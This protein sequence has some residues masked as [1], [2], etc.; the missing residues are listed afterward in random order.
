MEAWKGSRMSATLVTPPVPSSMLLVLPGVLE[1]RGR[2]RALSL[3]VIVL[4]GEISMVP[5][6]GSLYEGQ[7]YEG[8]L[9]AWLESCRG[10]QQ[11]AYIGRRGIGRATV[12]ET[13]GGRRRVGLPHAR[14]GG[15][16]GPA[17]VGDGW[18]RP[19][20]VQASGI[21]CTG[22]WRRWVRETSVAVVG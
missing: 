11:R 12:Q 1:H 15:Y 5:W 10:G 16:T 13:R 4:P 20:D 21:G 9:V 7:C 14:S 18:R 8:R 17:A 3:R 2:K 19:M 6:A 22:L